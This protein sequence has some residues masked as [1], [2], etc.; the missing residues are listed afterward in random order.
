MA[1]LTTCI[2]KSITLLAGEPFILPP[3]ATLLGS[4]DS[5][6][7]TSDCTIPED[8]EELQCY[9]F[10]FGN[11]QT[12]GSNDQ[13]FE[14][15]GTPA[16]GLQYNNTYYAFPTEFPADG[17]TGY[18]DING[19][20]AAINGTSA[21]TIIFEASTGMHDGGDEGVMSFIV[22]KSLPSMIQ[23][24]SIRFT[25]SNSSEFDG[26][27]LYFNIPANAYANVADYEGMPSC[28]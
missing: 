3:G 13:I 6:A 24:L 9:A 23:D 28:S 1:E 21:G 2:K 8:L 20:I 17:S 22:F 27:L 5:S 10:V 11:A 25:T 18:Y 15:G 19:I 4:T 26:E 14:A 7:F 16:V 12:E